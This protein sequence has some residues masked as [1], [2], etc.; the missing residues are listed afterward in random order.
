MNLT[1]ID[2]V[3]FNFRI[4]TSQLVFVD[5]GT[6]IEQKYVFI[7]VEKNLNQTENHIKR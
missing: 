7:L 2:G 1:M 3:F 5:T 4:L 6:T